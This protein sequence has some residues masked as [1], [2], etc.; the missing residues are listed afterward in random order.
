[1]EFESEDPFARAKEWA[2]FHHSYDEIPAANQLIADMLAA[3]QRSLRRSTIIALV[4][5]LL[6][7]GVYAQSAWHLHRSYVRE[8]ALIEMLSKSASTT[9]ICATNLESAVTLLKGQIDR[10]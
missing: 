10:R 6:W 4:T 1:M 9:A 7:T 2:D 8:F 5:M 3:R